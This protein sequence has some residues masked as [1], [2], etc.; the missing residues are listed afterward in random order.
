MRVL[1]EA[2]L[3][4]PE[5][6]AVVGFDDIEE[7]RYA[8]P[9]LTAISPDKQQIGKIAVSY[10]LDRIAGTRIVPPEHIEVPFQ[11]V[12]RE[13]TIGRHAFSW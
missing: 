9:S 13:S 8:Y 1:H 4:I 10:L 5:D 12:V 11:L 6:V 2:G 3:R 7:G